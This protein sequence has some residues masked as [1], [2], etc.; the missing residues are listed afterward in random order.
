MHSHPARRTRCIVPEA[1]AGCPERRAVQSTDRQVRSGA[2]VGQADGADQIL[3]GPDDVD[4]GAGFLTPERPCGN[5]RASAA[6]TG[7][8][9]DLHELTLRE[10][11]PLVWREEVDPAVAITGA[12][13]THQRRA[14]SGYQGPTTASRYLRRAPILTS[15]GVFMPSDM[16]EARAAASNPG[17]STNDPSASTRYALE[18]STSGRTP[19]P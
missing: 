10:V 2:S 12:A 7:D 18:A 11:V 14:R 6:A 19:P 17:N 8:D 4:D 16:P 3:G 13:V 1:G 5:A 15:E 9:G